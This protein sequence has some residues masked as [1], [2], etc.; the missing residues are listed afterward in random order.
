MR[1]K[2]IFNFAHTNLGNKVNRLAANQ[3]PN[4]QTQNLLPLQIAE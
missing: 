2:P 1:L 3:R 4:L